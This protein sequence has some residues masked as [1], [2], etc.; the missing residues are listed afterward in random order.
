MISSNNFPV[1]YLGH[2][3]LMNKQAAIQVFDEKQVRAVWDA[4]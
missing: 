4:E 2:P 3:F 1:R